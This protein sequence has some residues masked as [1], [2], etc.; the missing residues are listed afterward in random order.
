MN[1]LSLVTL[2]AATGSTGGLGKITTE[3]AAGILYVRMDCAP[4]THSVE[5]VIECNK[6][7]AVQFYRAESNVL[8]GTITLADAH[9]VG[10]EDTCVLN[11]LTYTAE[12]TE[13]DAV[14]SERKFW[15]GANNA[16]AA[17]NLAALL[18]NATYG[19]PGITA[20]V[21][22]VDATDVITIAATTATTL[23]FGQGTSASNEIAWANTTLASLVKDGTATSSIADNSST[24]G[25]LYRQVVYGWPYAYAAITNSD[26]ADAATIIVKATAY[27]V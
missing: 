25:T 9:T 21:A 13:E 2:A 20:S 3:P 8:G 27:T 11:G 26:G 18:T 10:D 6:A 14:A 16:A 7:H 12:A 19:V 4:N 24:A 15:T 23:Q 1:R 22:A 5:W 17:A